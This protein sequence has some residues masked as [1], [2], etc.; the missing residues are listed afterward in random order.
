[1]SNYI[2]LLQTD[3]QKGVMLCNKSLLQKACIYIISVTAQN[4][5]SE[6]TDSS[7]TTNP[8]QTSDPTSSIK[9]PMSDH[10]KGSFDP[11][12]DLNTENTTAVS[13]IMYYTVITVIVVVLI[14]VVIAIAYFIWWRR[15][16]V[17]GILQRGKYGETGSSSSRMMLSK[18]EESGITIPNGHIPSDE[19]SVGKPLIT[20][21]VSGSTCAHCCCLHQGQGQ[22]MS[23]P[24]MRSYDH[25]RIN[26]E[27]QKQKSA[28]ALR[29]HL[30][31]S[32]SVSAESV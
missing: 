5:S 3:L 21:S 2:S 29:K 15:G 11:Y 7:T 4:P 20:R 27:N 28:D 9:P 12:K 8:L 6:N 23:L 17:D 30:A 16:K 31:G 1:M 22:M 13:L 18:D 19:E 25:L 26:C 24:V 14:C 10:V 32:P